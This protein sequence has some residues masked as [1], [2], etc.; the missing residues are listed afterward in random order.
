MSIQVDPS[1]AVIDYAKGAPP[2]LGLH[3]MPLVWVAVGVP[4]A[5]VFWLFFL[6]PPL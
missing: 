2:G 1:S 5:F 6:V 3:R 4:A